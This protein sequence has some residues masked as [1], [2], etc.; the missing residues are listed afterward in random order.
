M[1]K[2]VNKRYVNIYWSSIANLKCTPSDRYMYPKGSDG[3]PLCP[4]GK[5]KLTYVFQSAHTALTRMGQLRFSVRKITYV[6]TPSVLREMHNSKAPTL[7]VH[8]YIML[9]HCVQSLQKV[10]WNG[11]QLSFLF[12]ATQIFWCLKLESTKTHM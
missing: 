4:N 3:E 1:Y 10:S 5:P 6:L 9:S 7:S 8:R 2:F 12:F 11:V